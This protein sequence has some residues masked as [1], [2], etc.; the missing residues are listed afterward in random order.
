MLCN[1]QCHPILKPHYHKLRILAFITTPAPFFSEISLTIFHNWVCIEAMTPNNLSP[2]E[3]PDDMNQKQALEGLPIPTPR[4]IVGEYCMEHLTVFR[5]LDELRRRGWKNPLGDDHFRAQRSRADT[6]DDAGQRIFYRMMC[7][8]ADELHRTTFALSLPWVRGGSPT[9]LDL[10]MAPGGFTA[11]VLKAN[12]QVRVCGVSLP[13]SQGG[14]KILLPGW[15]RDSRIQVCF[16]DITMLAAEMDLTNIPAEHLDADNFLSE[17]PFYGETFDLVF[18]DGQVLR[19]HLRAEYRDNREAWRL[20]TSQLVLALQRIKNGGKLVVLLHK[21]DA[22]DTIFLL[23]TLSSFSSLKLFKPKKKH[24]IRNSFYVIAEQIR[25][26]STCCR[27]AIA[28]WKAEWHI[29]TFGSDEE[30]ATNRSR[31]YG[32]VND[33]LSTFGPELLQLGEP[34]W[35]IQCDALRKAS[36][37]S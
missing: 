29:A 9:V 17:R 33:V 13:V 23:Y 26:E 10:C 11:S 4:L 24:A 27:A 21:L 6:A 1:C 7:Q 30:N 22:W 25:P 35:R 37:I 31:S 16:L 5:E 18:C 32:A 3:N 15:Q 19:T 2:N 28:H 12:R 14:H 36:F 34:I 20:L 8:I